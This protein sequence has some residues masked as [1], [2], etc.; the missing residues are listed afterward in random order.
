MAAEQATALT[1]ATNTLAEPNALQHQQP[2]QETIYLAE[3]TDGNRKFLFG[4]EIAVK[5]TWDGE[6]WIFEFEDLGIETFHFNKQ[7]AYLDF[8]E[9]FGVHWDYFAC[10]E[11]DNKL[12]KKAKQLKI[13]F[14]TLVASI[15]YLE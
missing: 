13:V 7:R 15:R 14:K 11:D 8:Q 4:R 3:V 6:L 5:V 10:E 2:H 1:E 9:A 12:S